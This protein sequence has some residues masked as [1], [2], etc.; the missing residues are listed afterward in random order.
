MIVALLGDYGALSDP[1]ALHTDPA[2]WVLL[3]LCWNLGA[4][5]GEVAGAAARLRR[6]G[7]VG[8]VG[9]ARWTGMLAGRV[10]PSVAAHDVEARACVPTF[11]DATGLEV[12]AQLFEGARRRC[13]GNRRYW[14]LTTVSFRS[15][16]RRDG[17]L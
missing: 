11:I 15:A 13:E 7:A 2:A 12:D 14:L 9:A 4:I 6:Q 1:D 5:V 3:S 17:V 8:H 16:S 10:V